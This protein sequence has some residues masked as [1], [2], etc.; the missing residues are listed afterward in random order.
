LAKQIANQWVDG[1]DLIGL[2]QFY[3]DVQLDY[4]LVADEEELRNHARDLNLLV[5]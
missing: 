2:A 4:L 1:I 3:Y 5:Q